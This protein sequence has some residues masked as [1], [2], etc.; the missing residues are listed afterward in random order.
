MSGALLFVSLIAAEPAAAALSDVPT[1]EL[2]D[3]AL[4]VGDLARASDHGDMIIARLPGGVSHVTLT[5]ERQRALLRNRLPGTSLS[6][7]HRGIIRVER[8][9]VGRSRVGLTGPCFALRANVVDGDYLSREDVEEVSCNGAPGDARVRYD[10]AAA[11]PFARTAIP[12]GAYLGRIRLPEQAPLAAGKPLLLRSTI[13][14]VTVE[15]QVTSLQAGRE[16]RRVFVR[17]ED[18]ELLAS[19]LAPAM[20]VPR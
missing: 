6:L 2:R 18:G 5:E 7:R 1:I 3:D 13:G 20:E 15:R 19:H 12:A 17:T 16:G 4:R 14:P 8:G 10:A 11:A 9:E